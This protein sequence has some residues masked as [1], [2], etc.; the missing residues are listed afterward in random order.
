MNFSRLIEQK[1]KEAREAGQFDNLPQKGR[2][3]LGEDDGVQE[4]ERLAMHLLKS[5]DVLPAWIEE[6]K[7]LREKLAAARGALYR[8][9][10]WRRLRLAQ[11]TQ[12]SERSRIEREWERARAKFEREV[13]EINRD[14]FHFNLRAPSS[15][16]HRLPLRLREEY[17][18]LRR[19]AN[20]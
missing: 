12:A 19:A 18:R 8:A 14:I 10:A 6:D 9:Y 1:L 2:L 4:D 13:E 20:D 16:V 17:D 7:A 3:D 5:N 11:A 15:V